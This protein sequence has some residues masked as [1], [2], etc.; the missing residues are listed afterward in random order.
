[1]VIGDTIHHANLARAHSPRQPNWQDDSRQP[2]I[3]RGGTE[4]ER[5]VWGWG[6][7]QTETDKWQYNIFLESDVIIRYYWGKNFYS[8]ITENWTYLTKD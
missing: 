2:E 8:Q 3:E 5:G 4:T 1:M 6:K 7:K